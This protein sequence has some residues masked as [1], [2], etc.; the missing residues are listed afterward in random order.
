MNNFWSKIIDKKSMSMFQKAYHA[1]NRRS[2]KKKLPFEIFIGDIISKYIDQNGKCYYSN[3]DMRISK[4]E[5]GALHDPYKMTLD[6]KDPEL[7]YVKENIVWCI[8][9]VNSFK[10]RM[11]KEEIINICRNI[12]NHN[13]QK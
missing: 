2:I 8:Y 1:A 6:C 7:G 5:G 4:E 12:L 3:L 13:E 9:C 10:Q 11:Q